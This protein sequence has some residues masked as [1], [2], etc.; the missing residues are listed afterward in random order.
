MIS[1]NS[2][3]IINI[4]LLITT[5]KRFIISLSELLRVI[6]ECAPFSESI[7]SQNWTIIFI[8]SF[9]T[10]TAYIICIRN[11]QILPSA[12]NDPELSHAKPTNTSP[13]RSTGSKCHRSVAVSCKTFMLSVR[14]CKLRS[15]LDEYL[16]LYTIYVCD[17]CMTIAKM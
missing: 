8:Q 14:Q 4:R 6:F 7:K 3:I 16:Q 9:N 11:V 5:C 17:D 15:C 12:E 1:V 10:A 13:R 2:I